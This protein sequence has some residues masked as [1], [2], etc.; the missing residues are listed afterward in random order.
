METCSNC[1]ESVTASLA[2]FNDSWE[3]PAYRCATVD[4]RSRAS[5]AEARLSKVAGLLR[6]A[7]NRLNEDLNTGRL[8]D[9]IDAALA[10][11]QS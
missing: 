9:R 1:G 7:R 11:E 3:A 10:K 5:L 8:V 2:H 6:E 4:W